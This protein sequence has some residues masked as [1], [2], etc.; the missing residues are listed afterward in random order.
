M[1]PETL[2]KQLLCFDDFAPDATK[3]R[4]WIINSGF[5]TETGPDG[6]QYT[7]INKLQM[8]HWF[9]RIADLRK[10]P[11]I[12]RLSCFRLNLAGEL[13]HSW[14]HSDDICA[15][16][17][18]VLYL[19][20]PDQCRGGTA[21][22]KHIGLNIDRLPSRAE[23]GEEAEEFYRMM[24]DE[25]KILDRWTMTGII[26]M[27]WNR[28]ITYPTCFFHSRFPFEGF[29][30]GPKDGRLIWICFYDVEGEA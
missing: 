8:K 24:T 26:P 21:F 12:P 29:G 30:T 9:D 17:A 5:T 11:I 7:G 27:K 4:E 6:A 14:V 20:E 10:K 19:N 18:S 23:L 3:A 2:T 28:F 1:T 22:W 15:K 13:P 16:W 25:W